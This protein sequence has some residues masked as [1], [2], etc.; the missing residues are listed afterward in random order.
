LLV[1]Q[2]K[3]AFIYFLVGFL[4]IATVAYFAYLL[5]DALRA[6]YKD[7]QLGKELDELEALSRQKKAAEADSQFTPR[8]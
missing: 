1:E 2:V 4:A 7:W 6:M 3:R 8:P 5:I